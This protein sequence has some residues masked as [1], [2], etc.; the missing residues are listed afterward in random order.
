MAI[1]MVREPSETPNISNTDDFV[2]LR[3]AYGNQNGYVEGRGNELS[4]TVDGTNFT[5]NSGRVVLQGVES[6][7]DAN[8]VT[9]D[10][11]DGIT[12][13]RYVTVY[14]QVN[15]LTNTVEIKSATDSVNYPTISAGDDLTIT[16]NGTANLE[17]YHFQVQ[18]GT[19][20]NVNK[21]V[22]QVGYAISKKLLWSGNVNIK[23]TNG[24]ITTLPNMDKKTIEVCCNNGLL[25]FFL[26]FKIINNM[27]GTES[28]YSIDLFE[29]GSIDIYSITVGYIPTNSNIIVSNIIQRKS[30]S[31][32]D[33][34]VNTE[35]FYVTEIY[36]IIE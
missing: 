5:I 12:S 29:N 36:E 2:G 28:V 32:V 6:D 10:F 35:N 22:Q 15:L 3:Y 31:N 17:L 16:N 34:M 8:G 24:L 4:N 14:F 20:S 26:K 23:D 9:L 19:I 25:S 21:L 27:G 33:F 11:D 13:L 7:I 18:N 1:K 30:G